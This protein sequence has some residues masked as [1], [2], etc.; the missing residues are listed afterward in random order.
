MRFLVDECLPRQIV[1]HLRHAGHDVIWASEVCPSADDKTV[2]A[3]ATAEKRILMTEDRD[4]GELTIRF[5]LP[6]IGIIIASIGEFSG[7][8]DATAAH[9]T[10]VIN[11][12]G[13]SCLGALTVIEP[14]RTR[15]RPL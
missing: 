15:Q 2:L 4:F 8:L 7:S 14:G 6:A 3:R 12:L 5:K 9:M 11:G 13:E 10:N 1:E